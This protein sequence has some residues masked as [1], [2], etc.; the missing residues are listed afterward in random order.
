MGP[1]TQDDLLRLDSGKIM[2]LNDFDILIAQ[3]LMLAWMDRDVVCL[4]DNRLLRFEFLCKR[5][6]EVR[7]VPQYL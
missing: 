4:N 3:L 5:M 7:K 2:Y 1:E 6:N